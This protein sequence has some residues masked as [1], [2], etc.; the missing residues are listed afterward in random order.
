MAGEHFDISASIGYVDEEYR[1]WLADPQSVDREYQLFFAGFQTGLKKSP[2]PKDNGGGATAPL[3]PVRRRSRGFGPAT[4][5]GRILV[6]ASTPHQTDVD[7]LIYHYRDL[8]HMAARIDPLDVRERAT[9]RMQLENFGLDDSMLDKSFDPGHLYGQEAHG[10]ITLRALVDVLEETYCGTVGAEYMHILETEERRWLQ[11]RMETVRNRPDFSAEEKRRIWTRLTEAELFENFLHTRYVGQKRFSLQGAETLIPIMDALVEYA[12]EVGLEEVVIGMPHRGRLNVLAHVLKKSY[13]FLLGEF[14]DNF[15]PESMYGDGDVKYHMGFSADPVNATG[16]S[17]HISLTANPSHLEAV[18]PVVEGKVRAKQ[19]QRKDSERRKVF[20]LLLHGD[21]AVAGQGL[22]AETFNL[23]QLD[24]YTTGGTVHIIVN[25]QIGF[26]TSPDEAKSTLYASDVAKI[27]N[28]PVFHVNGDDPEA[29]VFVT[30]LA[31][32]FRQRFRKDVVIDLWCYRRYGHNEMDEPAFTQP[33]FYRAIDNHPPTQKVYTDKLKAEGSLSDEAMAEIQRRIESDLNDA[34]E[35]ARAAPMRYKTDRFQ[36]VWKGITTRYK[37]VDFKTGVDLAVL[38]KVVG[39]ISSVPEGFTPHRKLKRLLKQRAQVFE[40]D[41]VDWAMAEALAFG[42]LLE[43]GSGVRLSGQDCRR[44]TFS[45]RHA[46]LFD[47]KTSAPYTALASLG[48]EDAD[49][50]VYNSLLSEAAVLGFEY[51]FS[52]AEPNMLILWE[53]QFGDFANGA[54]VIIDQFIVSSESKWQRWSNLV[55]L[56]PHGYEGQ[57]PE[58][59]SARLERFLTM[60]AENNII[61][62]NLSTPAQYFHVLR[63]QVRSNMRKPLVIMSPKS[64]LRHPRCVSRV[65]ELT[66]GV[67]KKLLEDESVPAEAVT[68]VLFCSGKVYYDLLAHREETADTKTAIVRIEQLY[69]FPEQQLF[70][71][72]SRYPNAHSF[73]WVQEEPKNMGAWTF[74]QPHI[75]SHCGRLDYVGRD[76]AASP[77]TGS[78][79]IHKREQKDLVTQAFTL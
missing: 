62:C 16:K 30:R 75:S 28:A 25:N 31:L 22:V 38:E 36:G 35:S 45:H 71:L 58:H 33:L 40:K 3:P 47:Y 14:E 23:S 7:S 68:K 20:P 1:K 79:T 43:E 55:M 44:G 51:G 39:A 37:P 12:P 27:V 66:H 6:D 21:A 13:R 32:D 46:V 76:A 56:L 54:Q 70:G 65:D 17:L 24:G 34:R 63:R 10:K 5:S 64:L 11:H 52:L 19:R 48:G 9:E 73:V 29:C 8:G 53:A 67:F 69:P 50:Y 77:A 60:C 42:S 18:G 49:F 26:T 15:V 41:R 78:L 74:V 4:P 61:V 59:S 72:L 57:G 2:A